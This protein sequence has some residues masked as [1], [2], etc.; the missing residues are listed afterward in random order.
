[1]YAKI[2]VPLDGSGRAERILPHVEQIALNF[3]SEV[4]F[5]RVIDPYAY[6]PGAT[7]DT[8][9]SYLDTYQHVQKDAQAYIQALQGEYRQKGIKAR[10]ILESGPIVSKILQIA[11][12]EDVDLIAMASHGRSGLARMFYGS[13]A[14]GVLHSAD[15]PLLLVRATT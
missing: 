14:S 12:S 4:I 9:Q 2:L 1:M 15:R 5:L 7:A 13:V 3:K 10:M 11:E 8:P 6:V